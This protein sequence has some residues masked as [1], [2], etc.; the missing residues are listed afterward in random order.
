MK[1]TATNSLL[2]TLAA[3]LLSTS[4]AFAVPVTFFD[5]TFTSAER[6]ANAKFEQDGTSLIVTLTNTWTGDVLV[7]VDV[8]TAVFF[9]LS[10]DPTLTRVSALLNP[11]TQFWDGTQFVNASSTVYYDADGQPVGGV[12]G[13]E[14]AYKDGLAG[15]PSG[16]DEGI[17]SSGFGLFGP[18]DLF[19][20]VDLQ[21]PA[22]PDGVQYGLLSAGDDPTTGNAGITGSGGLIKNSVIFTLS[23]L[24]ATKTYTLADVSFQWGTGL[25]EPNEECCTPGSGEVPE[26]G[27]LSL[28]GGAL[29]VGALSYARRRKLQAGT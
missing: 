26:P 6:A 7:P 23:G 5:G 16:A 8:L 17:S 15:A 21:S 24:D 4:A 1:T 18:G 10:D 14:W 27:T 13:G 20:G 29:L 22:S 11:N 3:S 19:P 9:T 2:T 28:F 12:V 25:D